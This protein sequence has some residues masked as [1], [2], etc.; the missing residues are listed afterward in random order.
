MAD[1][2][3]SEQVE[4][5]PI[6]NWRATPVQG[7]PHWYRKLNGTYEVVLVSQDCKWVYK[8][9]GELANLNACRGKFYGPLKPTKYCC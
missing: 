6:D 2:V 7:G 3:G 9:N 8:F 1:D 4:G 5:I